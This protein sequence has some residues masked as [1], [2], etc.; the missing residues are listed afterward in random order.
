MQ[1][2]SQFKIIGCGNSES[3]K[4]FNN[5][6]LLCSADG[7]LLIDCGYTAKLALHEQGYSWSDIDAVYITHVHGDHVFGLERLAFE[8]RFKLNFRPKLFLEPSLEKELWEQTLKGSLGNINGKDQVLADYFDVQFIQNHEFSFGRHHIQSIP[9]DHAP[10]KSAF[11]ILIDNY[12][13]YSGDTKAIPQ[14]VNEL[15]FEI[16]FHDASVAEVSPVHAHFESL[17]S[18]YSA[19]AC[20]KLYLMSYEDDW[21]SAAKDIDGTFAGLAQQGQEVRLP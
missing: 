15:A 4:H 6:A 11:G 13:F 12:L 14:V 5:N 2:V 8:S 10:D 21:Q 3:I 20:K 16:G 7:N 18:A 1:S 17:K 9:V 19:D